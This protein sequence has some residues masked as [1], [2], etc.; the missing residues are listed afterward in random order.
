M[1]FLCHDPIINITLSTKNVY[2]L[3]TKFPITL[4]IKILY[5]NNNYVIFAA[6]KYVVMKLK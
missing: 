3:K 4:G 6:L 2:K 5:V 1:P